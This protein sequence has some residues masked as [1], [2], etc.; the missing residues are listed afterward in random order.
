MKS[1]KIYIASDHAGFS[2]KEKLV[3]TLLEAGLNVENLGPRNQERTDYPDYADKVCRSIHAE[4][5]RGILICGSGQG[6]VMRANRYNH[7]RAALCWNKESAE[8][9]RQHNNANILCLGSRLIEEKTLLK[10]VEVFLKTDF[11]GGRHQQ[12]V[13]KISQPT[14]RI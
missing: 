13:D 14:Q 11:E 1:L 3:E 12:R 2:F 8:L 6:M 5:E 7:I 9:S 4:N 10:I